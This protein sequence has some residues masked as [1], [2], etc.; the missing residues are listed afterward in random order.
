MVW[1]DILKMVTL[2]EVIHRVKSKPKNSKTN[3]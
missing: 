1:G 2:A 3:Y